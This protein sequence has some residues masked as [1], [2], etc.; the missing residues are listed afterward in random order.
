[1][2]HKYFYIYL[3]LQNIKIIHIYPYK[4]II[5]IYPYKYVQT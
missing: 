5:H 3:F 2:I 1:M 4:Y